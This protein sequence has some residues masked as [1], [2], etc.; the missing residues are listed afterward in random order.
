MPITPPRFNHSGFPGTSVRPETITGGTLT[1]QSGRGAT[2][3]TVVVLS[4]P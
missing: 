1:V 3:D 4:L 2:A